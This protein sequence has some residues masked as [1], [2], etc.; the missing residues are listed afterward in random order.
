MRMKR[1][2]VENKENNGITSSPGKQLL[3]RRH[4][5]KAKNGY[6]QSNCLSSLLTMM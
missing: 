4:D 6:V 1:V 2:F 5:G 3:G